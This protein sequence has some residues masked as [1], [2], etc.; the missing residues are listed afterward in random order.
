MIVERDFWRAMLIATRLATATGIR[1]A[2]GTDVLHVPFC[3][4]RRDGVS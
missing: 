2:L 3:S 1:P 4:P